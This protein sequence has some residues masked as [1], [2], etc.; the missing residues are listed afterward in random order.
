MA[1]QRSL[2]KISSSEKGQPNGVCPLGKD[3]KIPSKYVDWL[4]SS[5][6]VVLDQNGYIPSNYIRQGEGSGL[7][8]EY[9]NGHAPSEFASSDTIIAANYPLQGGGDLRSGRVVLG[10]AEDVLNGNLD[11]TKLQN[12]GSNTHAQLDTFLAL[13]TATPTAG[14]LPIADSSGSLDAWVTSISGEDFFGLDINGDLVPLENPTTSP[15]FELDP[16]S[17]IQPKV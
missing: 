15:N 4:T 14:A 11:H 2:D 12:V 1:T 6:G 5:G 8:A 13:A 17:D 7:N 16:N 3:G 9:L 10:L